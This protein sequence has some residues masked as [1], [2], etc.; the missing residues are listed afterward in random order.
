LFLDWKFS[1]ESFN[2]LPPSSV[3]EEHYSPNL[4]H[5]EKKDEAT[6]ELSP[7]SIQFRSGIKIKYS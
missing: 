5:S 6:E 7:L 4:V 1:Y 2:G 3:F